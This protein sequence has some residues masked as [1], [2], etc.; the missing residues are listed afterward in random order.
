[1]P[2]PPVMASIRLRHARTAA[3]Q[4]VADFLLRRPR[5]GGGPGREAPCQ[6]PL[7]HPITAKSGHPAAH[8]A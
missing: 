6:P 3:N 1:M 5:G 7:P 4:T 2:Y 8:W